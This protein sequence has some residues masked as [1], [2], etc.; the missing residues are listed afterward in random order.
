M[1]AD[2]RSAYIAIEMS[3]PDPAMQELMFEQFIELKN[4]LHT[5]LQEEW[6]WQL[7]IR[8]EN[9]KTVSRIISV[10]PA[11][12]IFKQ[13]DWPALIS[14]FKPRII[15]LDEFWSVAQY[16]FEIFK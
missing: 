5:S 4:V 6:D 11:T 13:D 16:S 15:A 3:N 2:N 1:H 9:Y 8:D 12:S 14:F 7:H 10:L